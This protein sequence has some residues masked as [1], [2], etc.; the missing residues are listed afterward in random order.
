MPLLPGLENFWRR[1]GKSLVGKNNAWILAKMA[2]GPL[3]IIGLAGKFFGCDW[4]LAIGEK[5]FQFG[6]K[7]YNGTN[8]MVD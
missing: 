7:S 4:R 6:K 1:L 3:K 8:F 5:A 2:I